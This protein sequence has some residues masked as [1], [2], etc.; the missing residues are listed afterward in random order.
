MNAAR[1]IVLS[2]RFWYSIDSGCHAERGLRHHLS[3]SLRKVTFV[4]D[5][6]AEP[7]H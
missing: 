1:N 4:E 5:A 2:I 6:A 7:K 3:D